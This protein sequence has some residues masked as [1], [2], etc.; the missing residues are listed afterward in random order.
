MRLWIV[1]VV[2]L[3]STLALA[4]EKPLSFAQAKKVW[5]Q[6]KDR[7]EYQTYSSE[8]AQFNNHFRLDEKDGCYAL[9][10]GTVELMLVITHP[11]GQKYAVIAEVLS[12]VDNPKAQCFKGS[13]RGVQTKIPPFFPFVLQ[14]SMG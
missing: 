4:A 9:A 7:K 13:Y 1:A 2:V 10:K 14:M 3:C 12:D 11:A 8:F 6:S 5:E